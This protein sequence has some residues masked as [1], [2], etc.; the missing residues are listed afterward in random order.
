MLKFL[1]SALVVLSAGS[2]FAINHPAPGNWGV[3]GEYLYLLPTVDDTY[4]VTKSPSSTTFPNGRRENN[5]CKFYSGYRVTGVYTFCDCNCDREA[6]VSYAHLAGSQGKNVSGNFLWATRGRADFTSSFENYSGTADSRLGFNYERLDALYAQ[7]IYN[8]CGL[9]VRLD[10]GLEYALLRL[11]ERCT[12]AGGQNTG[13]IREKCRTWGIGPQFGF[14]VNYELCKFDECDC[15]WLPGTLSLNV[16]TSGSILAGQTGTDVNNVL[17]NATILDV[18]DQK[19][20]RVIPALHT[21]V[22][23]N[24]DTC[25]CGWKTDLEV[26]YEFSSYYRGL[27]RQVYADDVADGHTTT[28]YYNY[29]VQGLYVSASVSF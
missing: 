4:F 26:G 15:S 9:D 28:S 23:V 10:F 24:Y 20:C 16:L 13:T 27:A 11:K 7:R 29:D 19:S 8:C 22:G 3:T 17:N 25:I 1:C 2:L 21:R 6:V 5:D 12:F 18:S 14:D